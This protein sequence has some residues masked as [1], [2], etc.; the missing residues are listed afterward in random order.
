MRSDKDLT[1]PY[2]YEFSNIVP[3]YQAS[4]GAETGSLSRIYN[5]IFEGLNRKDHLPHYILIFPDRDLLMD[6]NFYQFGC[7]EVLHHILKWLC[8]RID[9]AIADRHDQLR[10]LRPGA[11]GHDPHIMW[12][13]MIPRPL[14]KNHPTPHFNNVVNLRKKFNNELE[15]CITSTNNPR[16]IHTTNV[17]D[18]YNNY[19]NIGALTHAGKLKFWHHI[20]S[21][22]KRFNTDQIDLCPK[23]AK[24][25]SSQPYQYQ[26]RRKLSYDHHQN[27]H[28]H[29]H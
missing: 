8:L 9:R 17:F 22:F 27:H 6:A 19:D 1:T 18:D 14:I 29:F 21:Q 5:S 3:I 10:K 12:I 20:D 28:S 26:P 7:A 25:F 24:Y 13:S 2:M 16:L 15:Q 11:A 23:P 4:N